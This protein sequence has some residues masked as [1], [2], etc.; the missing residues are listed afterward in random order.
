MSDSNWW[1]DETVA[2][3]SEAARNY[4]QPTHPSTVFRHA[5][6]PNR[7]GIVLESFACGGRRFTT[8]EAVSRYTA[9]TTAAANL[10][11]SPAPTLSDRAAVAEAELDSIL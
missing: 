5:S 2:T 4:P 11:T 10:T 7:H 6:R 1:E 3:L 8:L 9:K